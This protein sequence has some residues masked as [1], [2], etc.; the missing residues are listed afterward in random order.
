MMAEVRQDFSV[1]KFAFYEGPNYYLPCRAM[2]FNLWLDPRGLRASHYEAEVAEH[3]PELAGERFDRVVDLFVA[4]LRA[5]LRLG[6]GLAV[7]RFALSRDGEEDVVAIE[8]IEEELAENTVCALRDWFQAMNGDLRYDWAGKF[9]ELQ[10][11]FDGTLLG[12]PTIYSLVEA[13]WKRGVP[14]LYLDREKVFQWGYGRQAVRGRSTVF[15]RDSVK[16]TEFTTQK[17]RVKDFLDGLGFPVPRG[18]TVYDEEEALEEAE[19]LGWPVVVKPVD[20]HK[21]QGVSV[22]LKTAGELGEAFVRAVE[23]A[24]EE[25]GSQPPVIVEQYI[26]GRD[27]RLL[28]VNGRF[29]AALMR[30]PPFVVADGRR[31]VAELIEEENRSPQR[32]DTIRSPLGKIRI[33]PQLKEFLEAQGLGL[34]QVP[35]PGG[36]QI[37]LS[38]IANVSAGGVSYNVTEE[39][40]PDNRELVENV[41]A[42]F[43]IHCLGVDVISQ[44][45]NVSWKEGKF[46][47]IEINAGP[48]VFMHLAPAVGEPLDVPG[49]IMEA[50]FGD[51]RGARIPLIAGNCLTTEFVVGMECWLKVRDGKLGFGSLDDQGQ[52]RAGGRVVNQGLTHRRSL[53]ALL[54]H[55]GVDLAAVHH[56]KDSI[57]DDG[58]IHEG[59]DLVIL[60]DPHDAEWIL[61]RDL[62][63][64]GVLVVRAEGSLKIRREERLLVEVEAPEFPTVPALMEL[65]VPYLEDLVVQ[66]QG[67]RGEFPR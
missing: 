29:T 12:G 63:P 22:N 53:L 35:E 58:T 60:D 59:A 44:P 18:V 42:Y 46:G 27:H 11:E 10:R 49:A 56:H 54:R 20:G 25:S 34:D 26:E 48:G 9:R 1:R 14:V 36:R 57:F 8:Y 5:A 4:T 6:I 65:L 24:S 32:Q 62:R 30:V 7:E 39:V 47:I 21:G 17:D 64:G 38:N 19:L 67:I 37:F 33:T 31:T 28:T 61:A 66:S 55:P 2:V 23:A 13:G 45:L 52:V 43:G 50:F 16:D 3:F 15:H 40:H 41:A 51:G